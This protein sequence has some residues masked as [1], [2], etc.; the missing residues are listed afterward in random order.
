[1]IEKDLKIIIKKGLE[2]MINNDPKTNTKQ[3]QYLKMSQ[4]Y[5]KNYNQEE[6]NPI[7][8]NIDNF[9]CT[10]YQHYAYSQMR[11]TEFYT[12]D[13]LKGLTMNYGFET[14]IGTVPQRKT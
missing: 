5:L 4:K 2:R 9:N 6:D 13:I 11:I 14:N 12:L 8:H 3:C 7:L 10:N 1:M